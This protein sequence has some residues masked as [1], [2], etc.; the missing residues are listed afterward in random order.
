MATNIKINT[1]ENRLDIDSVQYQNKRY[2]VVKIGGTTY[3]CRL[4][5]NLSGVVP[6][7]SVDSI[8]IDYS[9]ESGEFHTC[10]FC[11]NLTTEIQNEIKKTVGGTVNGATYVQDPNYSSKWSNNDYYCLRFDYWM[12]N[13]DYMTRS[14]N[15]G[16]NEGLSNSMIILQLRDY[17]NDGEFENQSNAFIFQPILDLGGCKPFAGQ[18]SSS[19]PRKFKVVLDTYYC[20]G[21]FSLTGGEYTQYRGY[22]SGYVDFGGYERIEFRNK[23]FRF[24]TMTSMKEGTIGCY[25]YLDGQRYSFSKSDYGNF[26][27]QCDITY[28]NNESRAWIESA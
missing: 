22:G 10:E 6:I 28:W 11:L 21:S 25:F 9:A 17:L 20:G 12:E 1:S 7:S 13:N 26:N 15:I 23:L 5:P 14:I 18:T 2:R 3:H 27:I 24:E 8:N 16:F 19:I 4:N